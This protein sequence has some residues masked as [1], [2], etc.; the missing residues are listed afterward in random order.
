MHWREQLRGPWLADILDLRLDLLLDV[1]NSAFAARFV[2]GSVILV[3]F[4]VLWI[5]SICIIVQKVLHLAGAL[6]LF[7]SVA[8]DEYPCIAGLYHLLRLVLL[9]ITASFGSPPLCFGLKRISVSGDLDLQPV[10]T[11]LCSLVIAF[12]RALRLAL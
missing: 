10:N 6:D 2:I 7:V 1:V 9:P 12:Y 8:G 5:K 11:Y 3:I 4:G